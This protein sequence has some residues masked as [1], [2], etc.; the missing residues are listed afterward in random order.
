MVVFMVESGNGFFNSMMSAPSL[1]RARRLVKSLHPRSAPIIT[2]K[3]AGCFASE[4]SF[5]DRFVQATPQTNSSDSPAP[6]GGDSAMIRQE[7]SKE[8]MAVHQPDFRAPI[9][10][11]TSYVIRRCYA[12]KRLTRDQGHSPQYRSAS[13]TVVSLAI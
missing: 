5:R 2:F 13:W 4:G 1:Q 9:D 12:Y 3:S 7:D 6:R 10:H 8:G 11:G